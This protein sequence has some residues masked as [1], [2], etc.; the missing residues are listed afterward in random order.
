MYI[1]LRAAI[2]AVS[3]ANIGPAY[4]EGTV[5]NTR[6]TQVPG[7]VAQARPQDSPLIA[8]APNGHASR[9]NATTWLFPPVGK[10]LAQ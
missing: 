9:S 8:T 2:A 1:M 7:V 6:F 10:Y 5:A 4:A 3:I